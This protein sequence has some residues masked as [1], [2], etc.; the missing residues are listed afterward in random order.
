FFEALNTLCKCVQAFVRIDE[1]DGESG[2]Q[3]SLPCVLDGGYRDGG[4]IEPCPLADDTRE[5]L[6]PVKVID[7]AQGRAL[8]QPEG[9]AH[10]AGGVAATEVHGAVQGIHYPEGL[11]LVTGS[12]FSGL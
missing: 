3:N 2:A 9:N 4:A 10:A 8:R 5:E 7:H 1:V 12:M 6:V 11:V